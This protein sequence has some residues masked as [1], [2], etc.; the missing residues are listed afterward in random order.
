MTEDLSSLPDGAAD[1]IRYAIEEDH[2]YLSWLGTEVDAVERGRIELTIP[3]DEKLTNPASK[4]TIHGG[5]AAT[6]VDTA[7]GLALR[8]AAEDP[9]A[10]DVATVSLN[11]NYLRR[12]TGDLHACAD[13]IRAG[14]TIGVS[15]VDVT[16][17]V[18]EHGDDDR[19]WG[20]DEGE[21]RLVA[22]GQPSYRLFR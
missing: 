2:G 14:T 18:P 3:F 16:S 22:T 19:D 5:V 6:L 15:R 13:V 1:F 17:T 11:V 21:E 10:T 7:G 4:P 12:A 8:L 20:V 9:L